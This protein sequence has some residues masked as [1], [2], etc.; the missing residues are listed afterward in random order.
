[1]L[2]RPRLAQFLQELPK[3]K[4]ALV[5]DL[6]LDRYLDIEASLDEPS[7]ETGLTAYQVA[8]VRNSPGA[9]GTVM[10]NLAALGIGRLL[11]LTVIGDDGEGHDLLAQLRRLPVETAGIVQDP[12]RQ[13]PTYTKP[14]RQDESGVWHELNRL[15]LR[16]RDALSIQTERSLLQRLDVAWH[17]ADGLIV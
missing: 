13:T 1:M 16:T 8:R 15:D 6:F 5:G 14:M 9:L 7:V 11:P 3:I 10:N 2:T 12:A 17:A 4:I